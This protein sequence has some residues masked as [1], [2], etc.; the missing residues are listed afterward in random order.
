MRKALAPL[1]VPI[2]CAVLAACASEKDGRSERQTAEQYI[3]ALNARDPQGLI[4]L[5]EPDVPG[6]TGVKESAEKIIAENGG[7]DLKTR[8]ID[9]LKEFEPTYAGV[10]VT[11]TDGS[12][13]Q[14]SIYIQMGKKE[15]DWVIGLG[16]TPIK[17]A[18]KTP[19]T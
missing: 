13:K 7:R 16:Q 8:M 19:S 9:V 6:R 14:F 17:G 3:A 1:T 15:G 10:H 2:L 4:A 5:T 12:G 18:I 11:G